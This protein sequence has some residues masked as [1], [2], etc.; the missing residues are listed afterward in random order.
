MSF[1]GPSAELL[2][3]VLFAAGKPLNFDMGLIVGVV[4]GAF[5]AAALFG[6]LKL[7]GFQGGASMRRYLAGALLM[8]FGGMLAGGCAVGAGLSGA[9]IFSLT[10]WL[11]LFAI[12]AA[13]ALTDRLLDHPPTP[14]PQAP[15]RELHPSSSAT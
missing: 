9:A 4:L 15:M 3:R 7:E 13:A 6:E 8:G 12:W 14:S 10:A 11:T 1:T 2:S 5:A